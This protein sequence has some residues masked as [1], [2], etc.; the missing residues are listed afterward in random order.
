MIRLEK[1]SDIR[2]LLEQSF[3]SGGLLLKEAELG[4]GFFDLSTGLAGELFQQFTNY[5]KKLAFV[6]PDPSRYNPRLAELAYE[7]Q[8]HPLIRFCE[9]EEAARAWLSQEQ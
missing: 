4:E 5:H 9:T 2:D 7:H 1:N 8:A 6:V 3:G